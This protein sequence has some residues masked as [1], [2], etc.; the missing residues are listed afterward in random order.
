MNPRRRRH[1]KRAR[2]LRLALAMLRKWLATTSRIRYAY[3][4]ECYE[5][6]RAETQRV[7]NEIAIPEVM[8]KMPEGMPRPT[9]SLEKR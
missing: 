5:R 2:S 1:N 6:A 9:V 7:L 8:R 4:A 3:A